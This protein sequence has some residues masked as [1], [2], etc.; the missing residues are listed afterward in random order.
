MGCRGGGL[1]GQADVGS[2]DSG[3]DAGIVDTDGG[4]NQADGGLPGVWDAG[5]STA[6]RWLGFAGWDS[7]PGT[8]SEDRCKV[9]SAL[10]GDAPPP[11]HF[12]AC[13]EGCVRASL[14]FPPAEWLGD[15]ALSVDGANGH[16]LLKG[17][18]AD[19]TPEEAGRPNV[20]VIIDVSSNR[21]LGGVIVLPPAADVPCL[22]YAVPGD[23]RWLNV[24]NDEQPSGVHP[25]QLLMGSLGSA[26][27]EWHPPWLMSG[28][29][30]PLWLCL[31]FTDGG[32]PA[33]LLAGCGRTLK[34]V[35]QPDSSEIEAPFPDLDGIIIAG[36]GA[37]G[38]AMLVERLPGVRFQ[39]HSYE[40]DQG[41]RPFG[42][43]GSGWPCE[44]AVGD[45]YVAM[46]TGDVIER[47]GA[48]D[49]YVRN[50]VAQVF[51]RGSGESR[52]IGLGPGP[53][54]TATLIQTWG[55]YVTA[56]IDGEDQ[57]ALVVIR[58]SDGQVRR[59]EPHPGHV[60]HADSIGV[61]G[62]R[63]WL[64]ERLAGPSERH[65]GRWLYAYDL[66]RFEELGQ[67]YPP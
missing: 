59:I 37:A 38:T 43:D 34:V 40:R 4:D 54:A 44:V 56:F 8:S 19:V 55:D 27:W 23:V 28:A 14:A 39:L 60:F 17:V 7:I 35:R 1:S 66:E 30:G 58:V 62:A 10:G 49:T 3:G 12:E 65:F 29:A 18:V 31:L 64:V 5:T 26:G 47:T 22:P 15:P 63:L 11:L 9:R 53:D 13:G 61:D 36:A 42:R 48:C 45:R 21:L 32:A 33:H 51:D 16:M 20:T 67:P 46:I 2:T 25:K 50:P 6:S 52:V 41:L 57:V 24:A